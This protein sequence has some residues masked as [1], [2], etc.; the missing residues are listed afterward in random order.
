MSPDA[1]TKAS[2]VRKWHE[3]RY[4]GSAREG[5]LRSERALIGDKLQGDEVCRGCVLLGGRVEGC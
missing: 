1:A 5:A 4:Q 2:M 3:Q